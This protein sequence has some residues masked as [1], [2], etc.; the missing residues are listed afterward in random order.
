MAANKLKNFYDLQNLPMC[1]TY[2]IQLNNTT[3]QRDE[4]SMRK[5]MCKKYS[6]VVRISKESWVVGSSAFF[7]WYCANILH[8]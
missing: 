3:M 5:K 1:K 6:L 4:K 7:Q 2:G 8:Y